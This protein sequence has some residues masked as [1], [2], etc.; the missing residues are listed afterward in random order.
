MKLTLKRT[1]QVM[2]YFQ[3]Y[4]VKF[5]PRKDFGKLDPSL[6]HFHISR[7]EMYVRRAQNYLFQKY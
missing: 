7:L 6:I 1:I 4:K 3:S 5:D 2:I